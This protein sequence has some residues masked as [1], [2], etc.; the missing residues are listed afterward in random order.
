M[1]GK[2]MQ[3]P[4]GKQRELI[5]ADTHL[6]ICYCVC[7]LGTHE[8]TY[9]GSPPKDVRQIMLQ[10][11]LPKC[12][13]DFQEEDGTKVSKPRVTGSKYTFSCYSGAKLAQIVT[14]WM[15]GCP[16]NFDFESL[17][18]QP[19]YLSIVHEKAKTSDN[20]YA[21]IASVMKVPA[22]VDVPA[23]EN[24]TI[25]YDMTEHKRN[26]PASLQGDNYKWL[27]DMIL[28]CK[29]FAM[30]DHAASQMAGQ[31]PIGEDTTDYEDSEIPF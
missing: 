18:G 20:I 17:I 31:P 4:K 13:M 19:C 3:A 5:P 27:R 29:E 26:I 30:I 25:F 12:R 2:T 22:G 9:P 24:P 7:D 16:D 6:A 14:P 10:W 8:V 23:Q 15:G 21:N 11:E 28:S 1:K